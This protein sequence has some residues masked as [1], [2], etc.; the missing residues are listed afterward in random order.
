MR[1][2]VLS[3]IHANAFALDAVLKHAHKQGID[4]I[5]VLGDVVGYGPDPMTTIAFL[6]EQV[7][8][9]VPGN[10]D[11]GLVGLLIRL[12]FNP[13]AQI[14]L[15]S[16]L[17]LLQNHRSDLLTWFQ[18]NF[19]KEEQWVQHRTLDNSHFVL[20]HGSLR[21]SDGPKEYLMMYLKPWMRREACLELQFLLRSN[22]KDDA[23]HAYLLVGH[24]HVPCLC[25]WDQSLPVTQNPGDAIRY[26]RITWG[27]PLPLPDPPSLINPGSVGQP[28]DGD[29]R[30]SYVLL[31]TA[32]RTITFHRV[33]YPIR[34]T[35]QAM[36][37]LGFPDFLRS[38]L[39]HANRSDD[40]PDGWSQFE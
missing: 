10:H 35:K 24:T 12:S 40:W 17:R 16:N 6:K 39:S 2:A 36:A 25:C 14:A 31:D 37:K 21:R 30:A 23:G 13:H 5:W 9:W 8:V 27:E 38:R 18:D 32:E 11:A 20:V 4:R 7:D 15:D 26:P 22:H 3:D 34:K 29:T 28:R 19:P 33:E 1:I